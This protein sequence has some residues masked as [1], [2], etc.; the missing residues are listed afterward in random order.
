[1]HSPILPEPAFYSGGVPV[2]MPTMAEFADFYR[3]NKAINKYGMQ[4]GVVKVVPPP[5]WTALLEGT[6]TD[7]N[8]K[9]VKIKNPIMQHISSNGHGVFS[10]QNVEKQR[11]YNI[12]QWKELLKTHQPP[13]LRGAASE[14]EI[15]PKTNVIA[16]AMLAKDFNIDISEFT[17]QRCEQLENLYWKLLG[18]AEPMYGA[19]MLGSLFTKTEFWNVAHL[20]NILDLM[21]ENIPGVNDAYLYAGLW[22]ATFSWHLEDQDLYLINYIHFGAPKQWYSIPQSQHERFYKLM[23]ETFPEDHKRCLEFLR[24]K[25][26]LASPAFLA[27]NGIECNRIVHNQGEFMITY[28]YG[29]H[30]GFNY[31]FNLAESVNFALDEWFEFAEKSRKCECISDSV[32]IDYKRLWARFK[33]E[34]TEFP[35]AKITETKNFKQPEPRARVEK[36]PR[37]KPQCALCP[38]TLP[39]L[40]TLLPEFELLPVENKPVS[41]HRICASVFPDTLNGSRINLNSISRG[42]K[43][44][45]CMVCRT[46]NAAY[47]GVSAA[48]FQCKETKCTRSFHATCAISSGFSFEEMKC[49]THRSTRASLSQLVQ[50]SLRKQGAYCG[51]VTRNSP[52][53][54]TLEVLVYP[55]L[56]DKM[57]IH[58]SDLLSDPKAKDSETEAG[59][60]RAECNVPD[61]LPEMGVFTNPY[62]YT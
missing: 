55:L 23:S 16:N 58:Y 51:L 49:K 61:L 57:E 59:L 24:H 32:G 6:Y 40:L 41:V 39:P 4:S 38:N 8:L 35:M 37:T 50:F 14:S 10:L 25:T 31:G 33:G 21:E 20:P 12:F 54:E 5:E 47:K 9:S 48:C 53:E 11:S 36:K 56:R 22:K 1:M 15:L 30:A 62:V 42:H 17:T 46:P 26:F 18:Y 60:L 13:K 29:Y 28:P 45:K 7:E 44:L 3:Y 43:S 52:I 34:L 2:F 19:D 27:K